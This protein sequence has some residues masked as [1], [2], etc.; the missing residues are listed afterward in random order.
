MGCFGASGASGGKTCA[1]AHPGVPE[2]RRLTEESLRDPDESPPPLLPSVPGL[3]PSFATLDSSCRVEGHP[4]MQSLETLHAHGGLQG[5][6]EPKIQ[7][8][9]YGAKHA[10]WAPREGELHVALHVCLNSREAHISLRGSSM[11]FHSFRKAFA[12]GTQESSSHPVGYRAKAAA[13]GIATTPLKILKWSVSQMRGTGLKTQVKQR[14]HLFLHFKAS[15]TREIIL[16]QRPTASFTST[17]STSIDKG[18]AHPIH[19]SNAPAVGVLE[20]PMFGRTRLET[21]L[22]EL[23]TQRSMGAPQF[24]PV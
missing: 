2:K 11:V 19:P 7:T 16:F 20:F 22:W 14:F 5:V 23:V 9:S 8:S 12:K 13:A 17:N 1:T 10:H 6:V 24:E 15:R 21:S 4:R 3:M 18:S